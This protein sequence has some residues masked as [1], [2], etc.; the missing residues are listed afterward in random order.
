MPVKGQY[1]SN[2]FINLGSL[3]A[4]MLLQIL[5]FATCSLLIKKVIVNNSNIIIIDPY[6]V[7]I[8]IPLRYNTI[9]GNKL[10]E[11]KVTTKARLQQQL[12]YNQK[13]GISSRALIG[14]L[15]NNI[16]IITVAKNIELI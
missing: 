9:I 14:I 4:S 8:S 16:D 11:F 7:G 6:S 10:S 12:D 1:I 3:G 5:K 13:L 15:F 2:L